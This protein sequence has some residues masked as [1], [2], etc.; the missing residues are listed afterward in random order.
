MAIKHLSDINLNKNQLQSARIHNLATAPSVTAADIGLVYYNTTDNKIYA[1]DGTNW[2]D[3][4]GDIKSVGTSTS[5]QLTITDGNGPNPSLAINTGNVTSSAST[6][7]TGAQV[8]SFLFGDNQRI[9]VSGTA[10]EVT[11]VTDNAD[12]TK[13]QLGDT[14]TVGLPNDVTIGNDLTVT[15]DAS[16]GRN[17]SVTGDLTVLGTTTTVNST[18][19]TIDDPVFTLA[20]DTAPTS[21]DNK[22][23]GIEF[24]YHDGTNAK[25]GFFGYDDSTSRFTFITSATNNSEVF[26]GTTGSIDVEDIHLSGNIKS[27]GGSTPTNGHVLIGNASTGNFEPSTLS[28]GEGIDIANA[29]GS[30]TISAEDASATNKGIVE[31]ATTAEALAGTDT[32]KAVTPAGL[33]ARSFAQNIGDGS[34]TTITVDH[35]LGTKD[36]IVQ[37]YEIS[38]GDTVVTDVQRSTANQVILTFATAP[39]SSSLRALVNK[40][41]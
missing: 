22:D 8:H 15:N 14:L 39:A 32:A 27:I 28:T 25:L 16:V 20:G 29:A 24:R 40:I 10:N 31:L 12:N 33:A 3:I 19:V 2:N 36:V 30:I 23:R 5:D 7:T 38:T 6:L 41:D 1:Y 13:L 37:L 11:A 34:D 9:S 35:N 21:D 17:L 18:V 26:S 4:S